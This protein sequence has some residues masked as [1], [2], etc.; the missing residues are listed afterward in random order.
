M[1]A[2]YTAGW[3]V[4]QRQ[5]TEAVGGAQLEPGS[6]GADPAGRSDVCCTP[7]TSGRAAALVTLHV[8]ALPRLTV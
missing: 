6:K 4:G 7:S 1:T 5:E 3:G 2:R 8:A